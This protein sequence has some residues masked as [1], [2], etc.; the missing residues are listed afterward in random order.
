MVRPD[1][2]RLGRPKISFN[3]KKYVKY[4]LRLILINFSFLYVVIFVKL[5]I[6]PSKVTKNMKI[7]LLNYEDAKR[8][9][10]TA[11]RSHAENIVQGWFN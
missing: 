10:I 2:I 9:L 7:V 5:L 8:G 6:K 3:K 4:I 1:D 11:A